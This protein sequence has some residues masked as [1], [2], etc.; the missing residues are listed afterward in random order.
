MVA[1]SFKSLFI[2][3]KIMRKSHTHNSKN[4]PKVHKSNSRREET[5]RAKYF[6]SFSKM[7]FIP[8]YQYQ[9]I[10]PLKIC[11]VVTN[12]FMYI[13]SPISGGLNT[14]KYCK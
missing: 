4:I 8:W 9:V 5:F 10:H 6:F 11:V 13:L 12:L 2:S 7:K 14:H 3:E 1:I